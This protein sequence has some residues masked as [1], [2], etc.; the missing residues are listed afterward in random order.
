MSAVCLQPGCPKL[1][2]C[3]DHKPRPMRS[4]SS[5]ITG[6]RAWRSI[7]TRILL[8]D[9]H[10]CHWCQGRA[11]QVD[12]LRPVSKGGTNAETNLVAACAGCNNRRGNR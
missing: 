11:T 3:P 12:H 6:T 8:R 1:Q 4:P 2:P 10:T 9:R 5:R 7:R